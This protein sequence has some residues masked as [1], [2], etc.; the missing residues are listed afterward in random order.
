MALC[1]QALMHGALHETHVIS[2][3]KTSGPMMSTARE[4]CEPPTSPKKASSEEQVMRDQ[5]FMP[6]SLHNIMKI[7]QNNHNI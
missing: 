7:Q 4:M 5:V 2:F 3:S 6:E 1:S